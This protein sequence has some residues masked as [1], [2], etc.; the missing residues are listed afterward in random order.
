MS[1][2]SR[3]KA[4]QRER[5]LKAT[6]V[7]WAELPRLLASPLMWETARDCR[8]TIR[9]ADQNRNSSPGWPNLNIV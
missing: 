1:S 8:Q 6:R 7:E 3:G 2:R 5:L 4:L 9:A